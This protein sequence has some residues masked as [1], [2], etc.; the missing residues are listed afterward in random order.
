MSIKISKNK[1]TSNQSTMWGIQESI[2]KRQMNILRSAQQKYARRCNW[3]KMMQVSLEMAH[4]GY[5]RAAY[6]YLSTIMV[7]DKFP[8]GANYLSSHATTLK[9]WKKLPVEEQCNEIAQMTY[10][11][12]H[13]KSDRHPAYL[14]RVALELTKSD[15]IPDD[16]ELCL[17]RN[18][19]TIILRL[20]KKSELPSSD[21]IPF[22]TGIQQLKKLLLTGIPANRTNTE[23]LEY[24]E[25]NWV[26]QAKSTARLY[27]YNLVGR[28]F[29]KYENI[30]TAHPIIHAPMV[31]KIDLDDFVYDKHTTEGKKRK[32]GLEHFLK[33]GASIENPSDG[34]LGR[35]AVKRKAEKIYLTDERLYGTK[36]ANSREE[37]KRIRRTFNELKMIRLSEESFKVTGTVLCQK[38]CGTKPRTVYASTEHGGTF[39]V[40]GPYKGP[41]K[42][43]FQSDIDKIKPKFGL[44]PMKMEI[45]KDGGLFYLCCPKKEGFE[46]MN[47]GKFYNDA[48]LLNLVNVLIF[49]AAYNVSDTNMRNV[50][51]NP[52]T[53]EVLSVDEM[54][55]N[56]TPVKKSSLMGYLFTKVPKKMF[57]DMVFAVIEKNREE[58]R[59]EVNK[60]GTNAKH[61]L[62]YL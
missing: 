49:R 33:E 37:R 34:H 20:P 53:N 47:P 41:E 43:Q 62:E 60:Y 6:E 1:T 36:G 5:S 29:H 55:S 9:Q 30:C 14:A 54:T 13:T 50:M 3:E 18:V 28:N 56:R 16:P 7:E 10:N 17:A 31:E 21:D 46:N 48:I 24:F 51:V 39:F 52:T 19:E 27:L 35:G 12:C 59:N 22:K 38:S 57:R 23:L 44:I 61:L 26:R 58:V 45:I 8:N 11:I 4:S 2:Y 32:R 15:D 25:K 42:L 40:K